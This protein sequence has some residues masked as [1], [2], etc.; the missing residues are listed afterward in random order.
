LW[1]PVVAHVKE[2]EANHSRGDIRE[3]DHVQFAGSPQLF[4]R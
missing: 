1:V 2:G 3:L 4:T